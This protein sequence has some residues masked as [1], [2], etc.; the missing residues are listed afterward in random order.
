[1]LQYVKLSE[2][3][4]I[5]LQYTDSNLSICYMIKQCEWLLYMSQRIAVYDTVQYYNF[6]HSI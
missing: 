4:I 1:M 6:E 2:D 3:I 5:L